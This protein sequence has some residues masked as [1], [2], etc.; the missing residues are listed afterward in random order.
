MPLI[1][2]QIVYHTQT[3]SL[4]ELHLK[5]PE[6]HQMWLFFF[7]FGHTQ[8]YS[9]VASGSVLRDPFWWHPGNHLRCLGSNSGRPFSRQMSYP[10]TITPVSVAQIFKDGKEKMGTGAIV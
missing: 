8:W 2:V 1:L 7:F 6:H 10:L 5:S 4:S 3:Y 9:E